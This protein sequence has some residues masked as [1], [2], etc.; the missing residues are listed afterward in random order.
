M[1]YIV[2][3]TK[4]KKSTINGVNKIYIG[5]HK[6]NDPGTFDGYLGC[7]VYV[8]QPST[9]MFPKTPFQ[10][11]V[12]KYGVSAFERTVLF[13]YNTEQEAYQKEAELVNQDFIRQS[14]TYN[15]CPGGVCNHNYKALYQ[16][17]LQGELVK[18]WDCS[19]DAYE[20]FNSTIKEFNYAVQDK[21]PLKGFLWSTSKEID[22]TTYSTKNWGSP[23][24]THLYNKEGKWINSF[25]SRKECGEFL[26]ISKDA[27]S[28]AVINQRL[29]NNQY[30]VSNKLVDEFIPKARKQYINQL[31]YVYNENST[32]I[33]SGIG[34]Q[35]MPIIGIHSWKQINDIFRYYGGW[36]K[37]FW[38]SL[39]PV[40]HVEPRTVHNKIKVDVYDKYGNFIETIDSI[41]EVREKYNVPS[42]KIKNIEMGNRYFGNYIFK[43][44]RQLSK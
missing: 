28:R 21:H 40:D 4:N 12:K 20:F 29:V 17:T 19:Y 30:Y 13:I 32:L 24:E 8:N 14:F 7:G 26:G 38:L 31:I 15:A 43:Y 1:K 34:K 22:I 25:Y 10:Y 37:T 16:F 44:H 9:Y 36:Y 41:K 39:E 33:G 5:V 42:A 27:I 6:T 3:L 23:K 18:Y 2:Y 11:A 35:I